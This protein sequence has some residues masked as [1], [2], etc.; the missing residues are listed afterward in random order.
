VKIIEDAAR[1]TPPGE[2]PSHWVERFR[3][4]DLSVGTYSIPAGGT[5]DQVPHHED[6][7]YVVTGGR[8][9][10][11]GDSAAAAAVHAG[12]V[13]YVPAGEHHTFTQITEDL[14]L[15]VIFA[16]AYGSRQR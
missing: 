9:I 2:S 3:V 1:F 5:D 10:L 12:S 13:I 15:L 7:I 16:P 11:A 4:P 14:T 8:A 6:E